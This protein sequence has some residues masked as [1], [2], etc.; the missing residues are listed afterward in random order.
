MTVADFHAFPPLCPV[1][2]ELERH[3]P[4]SAGW[5]AV[6]AAQ[7]RVG[8]LDSGLATICCSFAEV[9]PASKAEPA[10]VVP[11][12][13]QKERSISGPTAWLFA[14]LPATRAEGTVGI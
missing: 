11:S 8:M 12:V 13:P 5:H 6:N 3:L 14:S 9:A 10:R 7:Q 1:R 4:W 2:V